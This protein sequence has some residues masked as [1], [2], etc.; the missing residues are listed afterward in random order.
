MLG[1][2]GP[3]QPGRPS[4]SGAAVVVRAAAG[5]FETS[6]WELYRAENFHL[7]TV[8][9]MREISRTLRQEWELYR[10][11]GLAQLVRQAQRQ[12]QAAA[13]QA[14]VQAAEAAVA[15]GVISVDE[16]DVA[17]GAGEGWGRGEGG[18]QWGHCCGQG[19]GSG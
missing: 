4:R 17:A 9:L 10:A 7:R 13:A 1:L 2:R 12:Q 16:A 15:E 8:Q 18:R 14:L 11:E 5:A 3:S 19:L 6:E